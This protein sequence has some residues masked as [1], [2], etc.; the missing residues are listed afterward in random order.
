MINKLHFY[1]YTHTEG[2]LEVAW[3]I[4]M[5][6]QPPT[7]YN[8]YTRHSKTGLLTPTSLRPV[9]RPQHVQERKQE[10]RAP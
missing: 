3:H 10:P 4:L 8:N 6:D 5:L 1:T 7:I 9:V 2:S